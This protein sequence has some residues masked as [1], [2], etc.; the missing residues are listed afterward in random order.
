MRRIEL[1]P[2]SSEKLKDAQAIVILGG[3]I[4]RGA[5]EYGAADTLSPATLVRLR[6]GAWLANRWHL[7]VLVSGGSVLGGAAEARLMADALKDEFG[8]TVR[9]V[10]ASSRDTVENALFSSALLKR[11]G[12][13]RIALVSHA[14]HLRRASEFFAK[15]GMFVAAAPTFATM[16]VSGYEAW[17]PSA[18]SLD[19][20]FLALHELVGRLLGAVR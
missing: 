6:Y 10:E 17:L 9:W 14:Y 4:H 8:V 18:G 1:A 5:D 2:S 7:P 11:E 16:P 13:S 19:S 15:E 3:G 20:S 12:I